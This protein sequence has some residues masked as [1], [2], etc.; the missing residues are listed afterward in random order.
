MGV[1]G[2]LIAL[3]VGLVGGLV[4]LF[5]SLSVLGFVA[6]ILLLVGGALLLGPLL[7][8]ALAL[9]GVGWLIFE[10]APL[11]LGALVV[12]GLIYLFLRRR[13]YIQ[14]KIRRNKRPCPHCGE[15]VHIGRH[16]CPR[17]WTEL[18]GDRVIDIK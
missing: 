3:F 15:M 8:V 13:G 9:G 14:I 12:G 7:L 17:C 10:L 16:R 1:I 11:L 18:P 2:G 4:G 6:F 5:F